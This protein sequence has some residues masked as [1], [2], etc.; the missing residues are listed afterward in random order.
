[1]DKQEGEDKSCKSE[2]DEGEV[3]GEE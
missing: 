2:E 1:L 3:E